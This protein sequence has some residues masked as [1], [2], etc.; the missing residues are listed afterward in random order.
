MVCV[1]VF[2]LS[3]KKPFWFKKKKNEKPFNL[4]RNKGFVPLKIISI[5]NINNWK[6]AIY[7]TGR[8][9]GKLNENLIFVMLI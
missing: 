7:H 5:Y 1:H 3:N 2:H 9:H 6:E 8:D 4:N